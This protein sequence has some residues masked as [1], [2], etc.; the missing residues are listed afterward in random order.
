MKPQASLKILERIQ[1]FVRSIDTTWNTMSEKGW[2]KT[3][4][5]GILV[6]IIEKLQ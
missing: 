1:S 4:K 3:P 6:I 5:R 2:K